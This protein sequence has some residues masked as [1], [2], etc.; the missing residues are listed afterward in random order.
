MALSVRI[1]DLDSYQAT[2]TH[3]D[4]FQ[5]APK[6]PVIRVYGTLKTPTLNAA[7]NVLVHVHGFYPYFYIDCPE[8]D[9][10]RVD[11]AYERSLGQYL[12]GC[13]AESFN[14]MKDNFD[15]EEPSEDDLSEE[16]EH[17]DVVSDIPK[18][19]T[20]EKVNGEDSDVDDREDYTH[21]SVS[22]AAPI[23]P[24]A[25]NNAFHNIRSSSVAANKFIASVTACRACPA[26]GYNIGYSLKFKI[27][28]LLPTYKTR[29]FRLL[30]EGKID[31]LPFTNPGDQQKKKNFT[32]N[33]YEAHINYYTQFL[34][35]FNLYGCGWLETN[36]IHFRLPVLS[37]IPKFFTSLKRDLKDL[38]RH[39][40]VLTPKLY[41]RIGRSI[42]EI[43][44]LAGNILNRTRL[45][46]RDV[47]NNFT[48]FNSPT[49]QEHIYL[50]SLKLTF[51]D[52]K[53]QCESRGRHDT[54]QILNELYSQVFT[55]LGQRGY[56]NWEFSLEQKQQLAYVS[57][58]NRPR[59]SADTDSYYKDVISPNLPSPSIPTAFELVDKSLPL[60]YYENV[61]KLNY[62]DDLIRWDSLEQLLESSQEPNSTLQSSPAPFENESFDLTGGLSKETVQP[63]KSSNSLESLTTTRFENIPSSP[64]SAIPS[65]PVQQEES[66]LSESPNKST[67]NKDLQIYYQTQGRQ[68]EPFKE[69]LLDT[70]STLSQTSNYLLR[71]SSHVFE[72]SIPPQL[73]K[74]RLPDLFGNLG[75]LEHDYHDPAYFLRSDVQEKPL[76]F[77]NKKI[78][79]PLKDGLEASSFK[80]R[81]F[82]LR[83][84]LRSSS[85][86]P[87]YG[88]T[89]W[90]YAK[91]PPSQT[92]VNEWLQ[93]TDAHLRYKRRKFRTQIEPALTQT[94]DF[95]DSHESARVRRNPSD[96]QNLTLL[97]M[98]LHVNTFSEL[99]PNPTDDEISM[100][101]LHFNDSNEMYGKGFS[102]EKVLINS[103]QMSFG[104]EKSF[105]KLLG[106]FSKASVSMFSSERD[107]IEEFCNLI[108]T[109]DPDILS[110]YEVNSSSWGYLCER[111]QTAYNINMMARL[112]RVNY[113]GNG[114]FGDR[115][116]Y[117]HTSVIKINGRHMLNV[118]R[119]LRLELALTSY[120]LENTCLHILHHTLPKMSN[121]ILSQW[122]TSTQF[123]QVLLVCKYYQQ[124][125][126]VIMRIFEVKELI[127]KNVE[128][129]RLIGIDFYSNFYRGS[130]FKVESILIRIAKPENLLLNSPSKAHVHNMRPLEV[131]PL[132]MEPDS[133]FY[134]SPLVV[135]DFQSLYPSIMIA[136]NYCYSTFLGK[137]EG[138]KSNRNPI[139]YMKHLQLPEG[140]IDLLNRND[141]LNISPNGLMFVSAKFRKSILS[142][143]L[144]EILNMR[145]NVKAVASAFSDEKELQKLYNSKQLALKLIA[146][147]TYGYTSASFS[148]RMPSSDIADAIVAT[149]REIM[150]KAIDVI[151]ESGHNAKVVYGDTDSLFVYFPGKSKESAFRIG[152][153]LAKNVTDI[154][155]DPIKLKFEKVYHPCVLLAKKRY[156][157]NCFE[158]ETQKI[159]KFEAKG[160]ET[161]R[162]DGVPAQLKM[163]GKTLRI[164]FETKNLSLVKRYVL[165]QFQKILQNQVN[166]SDFCFAK[167][168]RH[169]T[170]KNEKYLPPGAVISK[171]LIKKDPRREPQYRERVPYVVIRDPSKERVKDRSM[172][173]EEYVN[174]F[175]ELVPME[176]DHEY[177]ITRVLIPPLERIFNLMGVNIKE[178]YRDMPRIAKGLL[179]K[180]N[181]AFSVN[182]NF[183]RRE[184][185]SCGQLLTS[186]QMWVCFRCSDTKATIAS[187]VAWKDKSIELHSRKLVNICGSCCFQN[188]SSATVYDH[189]HNID[190]RFYYSRLK[191]EKELCQSTTKLQILD[192]LND[193]AHSHP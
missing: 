14:R 20:T 2:P 67:F 94:F 183:S 110:G 143:M 98:E 53:F 115:W 18:Q 135:L 73:S 58:L 154:F 30:N 118:W 164:L 163:V 107:M 34:A 25:S 144:Q 56:S 51:S 33:V 184:C 139:G 178:W 86:K 127:L 153:E 179:Q 166:V 65:S 147:V 170:Y 167:E 156:V 55:K 97:H 119:L 57:K 112:S 27:L 77:A 7:Y 69:S 22:D 15:D 189:C 96:F 193:T 186:G 101:L 160:I 29:L 90:R 21:K 3:L 106:T 93:K 6:V 130:Q 72:Y 141:G 91:L 54:S 45:K 76:I 180:K 138:F 88:I 99:R 26:Y 151:E 92:E 64:V 128:L 137:M 132:I 123:N 4:Q 46:E 188:Y 81:G 142:R 185:F 62:R 158:S 169:G 155:P 114:K 161:I 89:Q 133:A 24:T 32:P 122:L 136:Y 9:L 171:R 43:D 182:D 157:G 10:R 100:V 40:N 125:I 172:T 102:I 42:L 159:A 28:F 121:Q 78:V 13:L 120:S 175:K 50:T 74:I 162:R 129:S 113:K 124:R 8:T 44:I 71:N 140:I 37:S 80:T 60:D 59:G 19:D 49:P 61:P 173:P 36:E 5:R 38:V 66:V 150:R 84:S 16:N 85:G 145:I 149:G 111:F 177:Y 190:C 12:D 95:K 1:S 192:E 68:L 47:H 35:D 165:E 52:L 181:D 187:D 108:D 82:K 176:L 131:I 105:L 48:E 17:N 11:H 174:S 75:I 41:P 103:K 126:D 63:E 83:H 191:A 148:G 31:F 109:Y 146:N 79:V 23:H 168:V 116:G 152:R 39:N 117:T 87:N 134:K 70:N 104:S